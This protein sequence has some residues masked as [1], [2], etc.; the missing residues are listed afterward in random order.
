[1]SAIKTVGGCGGLTSVCS[2]T[3]GRGISVWVVCWLASSVDPSASL[4][5]ECLDPR[6]YTFACCHDV[7]QKPTTSKPFFFAP[8]KVKP[9]NPRD[10][11][12]LSQ[13]I[14]FYFFTTQGGTL[15]RLMS[16]W[17]QGCLC[18]FIIFEAAAEDVTLMQES[19][20]QN[21]LHSL[22]LFVDCM[23]HCLKMLS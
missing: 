12:L 21:I 20:G 16:L 14:F 4:A 6:G 1:M 13:C 8:H 9:K 23:L 10:Y 2:Q 11:L 15:I 18:V 5:E 19:Y 7:L 22:K 17:V 3:G